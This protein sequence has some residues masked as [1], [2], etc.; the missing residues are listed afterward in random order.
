MKD[1]HKNDHLIAYLAGTMA[2]ISLAVAIWDGIE[3]RNHNRLSVK[4][5]LEFA[6]LSQTSKNDNSELVSNKVSIEIFNKGLGPAV[7]KEFQIIIIDKDNVEKIMDS[8]QPALQSINYTEHVTSTNV[9]NKN[10]V[11]RVE[12]SHKLITLNLMTDAKGKLSVNI[13]YQSIYEEDYMV[14][15]G[16]VKF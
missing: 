12:D 4:P 13:K 14:N 7:I 8:W 2:I 15:S 16:W 1:I 10:S 6:M 3:T 11:I 9:L 5:Y